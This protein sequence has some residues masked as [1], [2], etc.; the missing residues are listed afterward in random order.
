MRTAEIDYDSSVTPT[1]GFNRAFA[2]PTDWIRTAILA[3][4][5][6]FHNPLSELEYNDE[7]AYWYLSIDTIYVRY[8]S[9]NVAYGYDLSLWPQSFV[10]Y[11]EAYLAEQI[12]PKLFQDP[13][14]VK[15]FKAL[16]HRALIDA[17][18]KDAMNEGAKFRPEG[19][20]VSARRG[21]SRRDRGSRSNLTG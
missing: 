8:I 14:K 18:S 9:N 12:A 4:D 19:S 5:E 2:K 10:R 7:G 1:F 16:A 3:S 15:E 21:A 11:V 6:F 17:R 13:S 20:W